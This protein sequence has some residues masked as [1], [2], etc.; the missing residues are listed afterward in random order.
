[1]VLPFF[2]SKLIGN[3]ALVSRHYRFNPWQSASGISWIE[4]WISLRASLDAME[5]K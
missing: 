5:K 2:T 4:G 1:M 3:E